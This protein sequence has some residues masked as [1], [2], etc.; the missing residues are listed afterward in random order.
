M[1]P[2]GTVIGTLQYASPEQAVDDA[3]TA[4]SD[5]YS[6]G[7]ILYELLTGH[8]P[9]EAETVTAIVL[10]QLT[11][12]PARPSTRNTA[13]STALDAVVMRA[14]QKRPSL[15]FSDAATF[16]SALAGV[17]QNPPAEG[18]VEADEGRDRVR[19]VGRAGLEAETPPLCGPRH[20]LTAAALRR[21][22]RRMSR[23]EE[24]SD[25]AA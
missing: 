17:E 11:E 18:F 13:V 14:L 24:M 20:R 21:R 5:L 7:V 19:F 2:T 16:A 23:H 12:R 10:K 8:V 6:V 9:F 22:S 4:A 1:T 3:V 15:R 25:V